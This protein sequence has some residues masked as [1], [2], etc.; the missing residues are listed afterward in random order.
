MKER[1]LW[2]GLRA[3]APSRSRDEFSLCLCLPDSVVVLIFLL[4]LVVIIIP[5]SYKQSPLAVDPTVCYKGVS[6]VIPLL[7]TERPSRRERLARGPPTI[8]RQSWE[9]SLDLSCR[10]WGRTWHRAI[11]W[12]QKCGQMQKQTNKPSG[13]VGEVH[14]FIAVFIFAISLCAR[15]ASGGSERDRIMQLLV[16]LF[17]KKG[18]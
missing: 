2:A 3:T 8:R 18:Y 11:E 4:S 1:V 17:G 12:P 10:G 16:S 15:V 7:Y 14:L 9:Q 6:I 13:G 5:S